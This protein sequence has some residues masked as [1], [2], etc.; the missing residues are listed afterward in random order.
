MI[1]AITAWLILTGVFC[2]SSHF[3]IWARTG[4]HKPRKLSVISFFVGSILAAV[5]IML[6]VG[7]STPCIAGLTAPAGKYKVL[8][9]Q[10]LPDDK[11]HLFIDV[12]NYGPRACYIPWNIP[13]AEKLAQGAKEGE[14]GSEVGLQGIESRGEPQI[15]PV[16]PTPQGP[17]KVTE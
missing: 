15:W 1:F 12:P 17:P 16:P 5:A 9:F 14:N 3:A 8:G 2:L 6:S 10:L 7:W 13:S 11:I 4:V